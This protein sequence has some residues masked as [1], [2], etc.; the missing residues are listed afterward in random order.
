[1]YTIKNVMFID[2]EKLINIFEHVLQVMVT[3]VTVCILIFGNLKNVQYFQTL[4]GTVNKVS[5]I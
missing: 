5:F 4:T 1:M 2:F 3:P